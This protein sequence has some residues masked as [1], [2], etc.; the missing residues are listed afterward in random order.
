MDP[1]AREADPDP[2]PVEGKGQGGVGPRLGEPH[3]LPHGE[4]EAEA[5][6]LGKGPE[7]GL[8]VLEEG[9]VPRVGKPQGQ[10]V[11]AEAGQVLLK[12]KG[13]SPFRPERGEDARPVVEEGLGEGEGEGRA[14]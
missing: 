3:P 1:V 5:G 4:A 11:A 8:E 2:L 12:P 14:V 10:G 9:L 6:R 7:E 13:P